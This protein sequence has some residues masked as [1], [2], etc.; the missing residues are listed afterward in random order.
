[1]IIARPLWQK[2]GLVTNGLSWAAK[3]NRI[4]SRQK[5]GVNGMIPPVHAKS[6][7]LSYGFCP[8]GFI[9]TV[10]FTTPFSSRMERKP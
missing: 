5:K 1:M 8:S 7:R 2:Q 3:N 6:A 10:S 9:T 4:R